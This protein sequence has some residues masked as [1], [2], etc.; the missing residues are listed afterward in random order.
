MRNPDPLYQVFE[1]LLF[2]GK[3]EDPMELSKAAVAEYIKYLDSSPAFVPAKTRKELLEELVAETYEMFV[4][5]IY[6]CKEHRRSENYGKVLYLR[7]GQELSILECTPEDEEPV[8]FP[9]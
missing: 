7:E 2:E 8:P 4:K 5:K 9:S 1:K 6:G 3:Y